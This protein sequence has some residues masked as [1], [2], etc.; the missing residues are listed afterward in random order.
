MCVR[1]RF[2]LPENPWSITKLVDL[3]VNFLK[4]NH[5]CDCTPEGAGAM[6]Q[7]QTHV[8]IG[9][10]TLLMFFQKKLLIHLPIWVC[11]DQEF[12]IIKNRCTYTHMCILG[13]IPTSSYHN[14]H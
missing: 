13:H 1:R 2:V 10:I 12:S 5:P 9:A 7:G 8:F 4:K 3:C 11:I 6:R 14:I